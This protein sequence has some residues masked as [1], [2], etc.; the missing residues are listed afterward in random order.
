MSVIFSI[1]L[2]ANRKKKKTNKKIMVGFCLF[3]K[4]KTYLF[5][6]RLNNGDM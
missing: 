1:I 4:I 3:F 2:K 6:A 5:T